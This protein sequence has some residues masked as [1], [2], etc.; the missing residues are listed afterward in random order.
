MFFH[1]FFNIFPCFSMCCADSV[2]TELV[3]NCLCWQELMGISEGASQDWLHFSELKTV[4]LNNLN[5]TSGISG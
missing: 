2:S 3:L 5:K 1:V 4:H